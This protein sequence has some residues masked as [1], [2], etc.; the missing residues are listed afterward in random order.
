MLSQQQ[1]L[2]TFVVNMSH[3]CVTNIRGFWSFLA[4]SATKAPSWLLGKLT[5]LFAP[6]ERLLCAEE[7]RPKRTIYDIFIVL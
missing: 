1:F 6:S 7:T 3:A 2:K 5:T 4:D